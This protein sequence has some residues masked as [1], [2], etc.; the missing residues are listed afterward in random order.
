L[1]SL[2]LKLLLSCAM[3]PSFS[4]QT[5]VT[6]SE[7]NSFT[8]G[9]LFGSPDAQ[10]VNYIGK[11]YPF[12]VGCLVLEVATFIHRRY[13]PALSLPCALLLVPFTIA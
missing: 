2:Y 1:F 11:S 8:V 12:F 6:D 13:T 9:H 5:P 10:F 3:F 4:F 7:M